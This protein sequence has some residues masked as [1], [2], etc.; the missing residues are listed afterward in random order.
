MAGGRLSLSVLDLAP[1]GEGSSPAAALRNSIHL[2]QRAERLGYRRHWVAEH[3]NMPGIA[4]AAPPVVMAHLAGATSTLRIGSGGVMLPNHS[5]LVV[6][7]QFGTLEA[8]HPG[9]IDLGIGRAPGT[10]PVTARAVR[11][12]AVDEQLTPLL[13]E[14]L[15]YFNGSFPEEHPFRHIEATPGLGY[16]P[17]LW[18]L[19]SSDYSAQ[20]AGLLGLPFSFA[21]H[22][23]SRN[24]DTAVAIYRDTFR[25]SAMLSEPYVML[26]VSVVCADDHSRARWLAAPSR[27]SFV[28]LRRGRPGRLPTPEEAARYQFT[29]AERAI[30]ESWT[31]S[32]VIGDPAAVRQELLDLVDRTGADELII[33]THVHGH[34]DRIR[35]YELVAKALELQPDGTAAAEVGSSTH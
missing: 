22:F 26:G 14:L 7:E 1:V 32:H 12:G 16:Q 34:D 5:P 28:R 27:L 20:L 29:P 23:S 11:R 24:T 21:H 31:A 17:A 9:R 8:L 19:G 33:T 18:L 2:A 15:G 6:A 10:D 30:A 25:P 13:G 4:S 35:S 3:H